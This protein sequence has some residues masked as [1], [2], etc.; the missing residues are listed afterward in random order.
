MTVYDG[1]IGPWFLPAF[2]EAT[3]LDCLHY[4]VLLPSVETCVARVATR[5]GHGFTDEPAPRKMHEEFAG[6]VVDSRCVL[7]DLSDDVETVARKILTRFDDGT[8]TYPR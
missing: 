4:V 8:L 7:A 6:A 3:G 1:V 5:R 2:A